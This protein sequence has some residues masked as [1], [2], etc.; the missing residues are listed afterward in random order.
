MNKDKPSPYGYDNR[1]PFTLYQDDNG[2]WGLI[3]ADGVRLP[4]EFRRSD[5]GEIFSRVPWENVCFDS[6]EGFELLSWYDPEEVW[7]K[8]TFDDPAYHPEKWG[9]YLWRRERGTI[10]EYLSVFTGI[11]P[12]KDAWLIHLLSDYSRIIKETD[13][14]DDDMIMKKLL[15]RHPCPDHD[16]PGFAGWN[17]LLA[18]ILDNPDIPEDAKVVL[19]CGKVSLDHDLRYY[20]KIDTYDE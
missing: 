10:D 11:I 19:W 14:D 6:Q 1:P 17:D 7:F 5:D 3:D 9:K 2:L 12:D 4:A 20:L 13:S 18:P 16:L 15:Q 8:F